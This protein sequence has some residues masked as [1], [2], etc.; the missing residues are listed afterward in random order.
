[1]SARTIIITGASRGIGL[2]TT[3][4]LLQEGTNVVAVQRCSPPE[5]EALQK[6]YPDTF[7]TVQGDSSDETVL[8]R[9]VREAQ[10]AFG[11]IDS[12]VFNSAISGDIETVAKL[13]PETWQRTFD[14]NVFGVVKLLRE[15]LPVVKDGARLVLVSSSAAE[16]AVPGVSVYAATKAAL[17]SLNRTLAAES[18]KFISVAIDPGTVRTPGEQQLLADVANFIPPEMRGLLEQNSLEP[19]VAG[20]TIANLALRAPAELSGRYVQWND[21]VLSG[22]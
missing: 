16:A 3:R 2:A 9:A 15:V 17:N 4:I 14:V 20:R 5:H 13:S 1:M 7:R 10:E 18:P 8:K 11:A 22:L 12:V 21:P 6:Q 19:D